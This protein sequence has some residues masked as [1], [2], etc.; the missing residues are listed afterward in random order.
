MQRVPLLSTFLII[1]VVGIFLAAG[2]M[3][4]GRGYYTYENT[5]YYYDTSDWYEW[6]DDFGCW[7]PTYVDAELKRNYREYYESENW[8]TDSGTENFSDSKYYRESEEKGE[9]DWNNDWD[10][11]WDDD[12]D[13]D[14]SYDDWDSDW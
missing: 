1:F 12:W 3:G 10:D 8:D 9:N 14:D 5:S 4:P 11:D 13:W 7:Y 6:D 2:R